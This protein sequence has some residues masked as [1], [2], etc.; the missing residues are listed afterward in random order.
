MKATYPTTGTIP[1]PI[2]A[3]DTAPAPSRSEAAGRRGFRWRHLLL[4][5]AGLGAAAVVILVLSF[6]PGREVRAL[7]QAAL[8]ASP[9]T[10]E[11]QVEFGIGRLPVWFA[12][13]GLAFVPLEPE[14]RAGME[15]FQCADVAV[16][17]HRAGAPEVDRDAVFAKVRA[18][19]ERQGWE[20]LA[21]V[22][23]GQDVVGI[24]TPA[25]VSSTSDRLRA[26]VFVMDG[27]DLVV[28]SAEARLQPLLELAWS[29][30]P[31]LRKELN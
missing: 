12:K 13:A 2:V 6:L 19:M 16:Y 1:F 11:R 24:F 14:V 31:L 25:S 18:A 23:D 22:R 15:A 4:A 28:V 20:P 27:R 29:R 9:D 3:P 10:W 7:R 8:D 26:S 5:L 30:S 21:L 17:Q